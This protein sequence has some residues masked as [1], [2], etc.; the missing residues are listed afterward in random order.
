[1][2]ERRYRLGVDIGG[3]FT[4]L[5]AMD[6]A[7]GDLFALKIPST[8]DDPSDAVVAGIEALADRFDIKAFHVQILDDGELPLSV[9]EAKIDN[10]I[11]SQT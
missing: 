9:L 3:T 5:H 6:E 2:S 1:M 7:S 10:W 4:D 8:P 11:A